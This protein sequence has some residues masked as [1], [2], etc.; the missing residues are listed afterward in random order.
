MEVY[1]LDDQ[2]RRIAVIDRF[3]SVIWTDR[4]RGVGDFEL[5][6][7]STSEL[8]KML[9]VGTRLATNVS[10][11]FMTVEEYSDK[12]DDQGR[13]LLTVKGM[14]GESMLMQRVATTG[15]AGLTSDTD[16]IINGTPGDIARWIFKQIC[17]DG[18]LNVS[19]KIPFYVPG[20]TYP[21]STIP[22][23]SMVF[24]AAIELSSVY[25]AIKKL[26]DV[27]DLGFRLYRNFDKSEVYFNIYTGND[28][29]SQQTV[30]PQVIFSPELDNLTNP[31]ELQSIAALKNVA[32]V[33]AQHGSEIVYADGASATTAGFSRR[34]MYVDAR[35]VDTAAGP[36]LTSIL[37]NK[38]YEALAQNR[39]VAA[40]DGEVNQHT[41]YRPRID[42]DLG[43]LVE[44]RNTDGATNEMRVTEIIY[45][46][47]AEGERAYPTLATEAYITPG[48]W[49]SWD[50]MGNW[51]D[52]VGTWD[53]A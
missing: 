23:P 17:V 50:A 16:W 13:K 40:F 8:R 26:C 1:V 21:A 5:V 22:E 37:Q 39:A 44:M 6:V 43:D 28:R 51:D 52:A 49:D 24:S 20:S 35:D 15:M 53:E 36:E 31:S 19:D 18:I 32:Y 48:S 2:L 12:K 9:P 14:S 42:Y 38:G 29:T 33:F 41:K 10:D 11:R 34:V 25:D 46:S 47:D 3:E 30:Y 4:W 27:Y 45:V 7:H